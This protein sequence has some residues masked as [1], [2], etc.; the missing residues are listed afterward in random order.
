M[1]TEKKI[2]TKGSLTYTT[3]G[4]IVLFCWLLWGDFAWGLKERAVGFVAG[5]MVKS[6]GISNFWYGV[7]MTSYPC[8]TN[9]FLMPVISFWSD[10]HRGRLG[11]RIPFLLV[12][13]PFVVVGLLGLAVTPVLGAKLHQIIGT[14]LVSLNL[15]RLI[16]F[17]VFWGL[18]DFGT[19]LTNA[20]FVALA[21]D[22]VPTALIGRFLSMFRMMSLFCAVLFNYCILGYA[23]THS[24]LIFSGLG[25]FYGIGLYSLCLKV[26]EGEYPPPDI[27]AGQRYH[28]LDAVRTYFR[29]C[30]ALPY[31]R[32]MILGHV[33]SVQSVL[34]VNMYVIFFAKD[35][36]MSTD[37]FGKMMAVV[38]MLS[39]CLSFLW[40]WLADKFHPV[41][42]G[43]VC[44]LLLIAVQAVGGFL[45]DS[46]TTFMAIFMLHEC[47]IMSFNTLMA[48]YPQRLFPR[49]YFAQ[50]NSAMMMVQ[51]ISTVL[52]APLFGWIL[53]M[54]NSQ[55]RFIF[56]IGC[57]LGICGFI[58]LVQTYRYY[59]YYGGDSGYRPPMK[60]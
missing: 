53:D 51:S 39:F 5:L 15:A 25:I 7:M 47:T 43:M 55:Y 33:F 58:C 10:R 40:G 44:I 56:P 45:I 48:S 29:E 12:T 17:A 19:T 8:F 46:I 1:P 4:V 35:L 23:E 26:K 52:L 60:Q 21:N 49:A 16:V 42:C 11:R 38:F 22:V 3:G 9:I 57:V 54:L 41:R 20:L 6:F 34:A 31:Y 18:L 36:G 32:W 14:D 27:A 30:F 28:F 50:F 59:Q 13:T 37:D 2:W 24:F